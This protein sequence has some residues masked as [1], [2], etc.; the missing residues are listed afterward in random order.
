VKAGRAVQRNFVQYRA[1]RIYEMPAVEVFI[2]PS[3]ATPTGVGEPGV[4]PLA[5]AVAN[6]VLRAGGPAVTRLPFTRAGIVSA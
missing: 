4:P 3:T 2:V 5:P 6:A 1:L